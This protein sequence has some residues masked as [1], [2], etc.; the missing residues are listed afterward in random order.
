MYITESDSLHEDVRE[1]RIPKA[2]DKKLEGEK[3]EGTSAPT[4][5]TYVHAVDHDVLHY[6][7]FFF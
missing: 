7:S 1:G 2:D 3:D 4:N 5:G 6:L